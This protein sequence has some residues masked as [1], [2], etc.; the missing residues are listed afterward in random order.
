MISILRMLEATQRGQ[1]KAAIFLSQKDLEC[2]LG[3]GEGGSEKAKRVDRGKCTWERDY[4][5]E[6]C[7]YPEC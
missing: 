3:E 6:D 5:R 1:K 7:V 2:D 4:L